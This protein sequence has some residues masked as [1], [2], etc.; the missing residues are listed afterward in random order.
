MYPCIELTGIRDGFHRS[1]DVSRVFMINS[2]RRSNR[3][4]EEARWGKQSGG[5]RT[6]QDESIRERIELARSGFASVTEHR[7][8]FLSFYLEMCRE[9][10]ED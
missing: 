8:L 4:S 2:A 5:R 10:E 7:I 3:A 9:R 6:E 1:V